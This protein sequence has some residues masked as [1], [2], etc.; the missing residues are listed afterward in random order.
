MNRSRQV[1]VGIAAA[2]IVAASPASAQEKLDGFAVNSFEPSE[3]D[4]DWFSLD[5]FDFSQPLRPA[6]GIVGDLAHKPLVFH[7]DDEEVA[8]PIQ[9]TVGQDTQLR[10]TLQLNLNLKQK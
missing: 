8:V 1:A 4:S 9:I 3:R 7:Q 6:V 5:T 10:L 2:I